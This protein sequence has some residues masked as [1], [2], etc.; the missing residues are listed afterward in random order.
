MTSRLWLLAGMCFS[1]QAL[2]QVSFTVLSPPPNTY[3]A[4]MIRGMSDDGR[5]FVGS[6]VDAQGRSVPFRWSAS[7]GY[8][9]IPI[10]AGLDW[11]YGQHVSGDGRI[12]VGSMLPSNTGNFSPWS[13]VSVDGGP[14]TR[15][16]NSS[17]AGALSSDGTLVGVYDHPD[18]GNWV[19][20][21]LWDRST[22]RAVSLRP[23][24]NDDLYSKR[25]YVFGSTPDGSRMVGSYSNPSS[26]ARIAVIWEITRSPQALTAALH[27]LPALETLES[28]DAID[29]SDDGRIVAGTAY[30]G[31][32]QG[33]T[34]VRVD[35]VALASES[36]GT[37]DGYTGS[38][39]VGI[40]GNGWAVVG[41]SHSNS[42]DRSTTFYWSRATGMTSLAQILAS[43]G[44]DLSG[45]THLDAVAI[46]SDGGIVCGNGKDPGGAVQGWIV[47]LPP[48]LACP[49]DFDNSGFVD[50]DDYHAFVAAFEAGVSEADFDGSGFVDTDDF[51]AF[52]AAFEVGC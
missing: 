22:G 34:P 42:P 38:S 29:I 6:V 3:Q 33:E 44:I 26:G 5:Y 10:D 27:V 41:R 36:L 46:S 1:S 28:L 51:D 18:P 4:P 14:M 11:A 30:R 40:S 52:V 23:E 45:W 2:A 49:A 19:F 50:V 7:E 8:R 43:A 17:Y 20:A 12:I 25:R 13:A 35:V 9:I 48:S 47:T 37:L 31:A 32:N 21:K 15:A 24:G 16:F 39:T